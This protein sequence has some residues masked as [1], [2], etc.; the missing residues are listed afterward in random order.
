[1]GSALKHADRHDENNKHLSRLTRTRL[2]TQ[3]YPKPTLDM[4][5]VGFPRRWRI[6][7]FT[8]ARRRIWWPRTVLLVDAASIFTVAYLTTLSCISMSSKHSITLLVQ[9]SDRGRGGLYA[10]WLLSVFSTNHLDKYCLKVG[11][12]SVVGIPTRY[13]L[14]GLG[15]ELQWEQETFFSPQPSR[16]VLGPP[17]LLYNGNWGSFL[18]VKQSGQGNVHPPPSS[19]EV[20]NGQS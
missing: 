14:D 9:C 2:K 3:L 5:D 11:W 4:W 18:V 6:L 1:M 7:L 15:F 17:S 13:R 8:G 19:A 20:K 16:L 10:T 12:G